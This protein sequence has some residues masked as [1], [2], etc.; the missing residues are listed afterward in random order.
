MRLQFVDDGTFVG[1]D[2]EGC[3]GFRLYGWIWFYP[4]KENPVADKE[5]RD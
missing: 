2:V 3:T 1:F 5:K 4:V